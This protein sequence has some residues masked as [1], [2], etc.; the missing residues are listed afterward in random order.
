MIK[1]SEI[2]WDQ[3]DAFGQPIKRVDLGFNY[4]TVLVVDLADWCERHEL[5]VFTLHCYRCSQDM[6]ANIPFI[7][8][9]KRGLL[10]EPCGCKRS[11]VPFSVVVKEVTSLSPM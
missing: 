9:D 7:A 6:V 11:N 5:E 3:W 10:S 4:M 8:K 2:Q 1:N